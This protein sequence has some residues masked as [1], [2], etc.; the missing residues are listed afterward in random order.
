MN[1]PEYTLRITIK[2]IE[3]KTDK[4]FNRYHL[5]HFD[6]SNYNHGYAFSNST[7]KPTFDILTE[8]PE[9]LVNRW[10]KIVYQ[11]NQTFNR[12]FCQ[13]KSISLIE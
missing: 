7:E 2:D 6:N 13:V 8:S 12:S 1:Q 5:I 9:K 10:V 3:P 4:N 11:I